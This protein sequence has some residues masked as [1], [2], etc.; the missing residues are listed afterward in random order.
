VVEVQA[1]VGLET[2]LTLDSTRMVAYGPG[3]CAATYRLGPSLFLTPFVSCGVFLL[4]S[5]NHPLVLALAS[6]NATA[7]L[8]EWLRN[9]RVT[10]AQLYPTYWPGVWSGADVVTSHL[11]KDGQAGT[12]SWPAMP[13]LCTHPHSWPVYSAARLSGL[14]F[15][16][17]GMRLVPAVPIRAG[18]YRYSTRMASV[19]RIH[20]RQQGRV[21]YSGKYQPV[22]A[23][24]KCAVWLD[25]R[26]AHPELLAPPAVGTSPVMA[27]VRLSIEHEATIVGAVPPEQVQ[28]VGGELELNVAGLLCG[29]GASLVFSVEFSLD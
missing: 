14:T 10:Q 23:G 8:E 6:V 7:A 2:Q 20:H 21:E 4:A 19:E 17:A 27:A 15:D 25:L 5:Q 18:N 13:V 24:G 12:Q 3:T 16:S 26:V 11:S 1:A 28:V 29:P 9:S 22:G